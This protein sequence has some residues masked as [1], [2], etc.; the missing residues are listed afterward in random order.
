[1]GRFDFPDNIV[2]VTA[3][4]GSECLL[5]F[6]KE[7]TVLMEAG[8]S[9]PHEKLISNIKKALG[10]RGR[11]GLDLITLSHSH[12]DHIGGLPYLLDEWPDAKVIAAEKTAKVF[13]SKGACE[14]IRRLSREAALTFGGD[15]EEPDTDMLRV[16]IIA[17]DGDRIDLGSGEYIKVLET[18]GHTDCSLTYVFEPQSIM[19]SSESTGVIRNENVI[20]SAVLKSY[21]DAVR[22]ARKCMAY[23][24]KMLITPH[25]GLMKK[26]ENISFFIWFL[27]AAARERNFIVR[28][29]DRTGS[30]AETLSEYV[31][32]YWSEEWLNAQPKAAFM[33]NARYTV[34]NVL[35]EAGRK[36]DG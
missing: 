16:D 20:T 9:F 18:K 15:T 25:Y 27:I 13:R 36:I 1:M 33:E 24:P 11:K 34:R 7:K 14:T 31:D 17:R 28:T 26:E 8:L 2:R 5:V 30:Y 29:F 23:K 12:Y 4:R 32:R 35:E 21:N 3:G 19:F 10:E 6:T 22:S